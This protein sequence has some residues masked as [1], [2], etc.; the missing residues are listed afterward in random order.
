MPI[1]RPARGDRAARNPGGPEALGPLAACFASDPDPE[2]RAL[3]QHAGKQIYYLV[4]RRASQPATASQDQRQ[5]AADI[6]ARARIQKH[7]R[8]R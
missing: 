3:A 8:G 1:H 6:L 7:K 5:Q 2:L 4:M